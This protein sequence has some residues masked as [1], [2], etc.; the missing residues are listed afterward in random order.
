MATITYQA[1]QVDISEP[2]TLLEGLENA[3]FS[4][5]FSCRSGICHSC[6]MQA[7]EQ[8]PISSQVGLSDN[9]KAQHFFLA[10]SCIPNKAM[11]VNL[12]AATNKLSATVKDKQLVNEQVA[13]LKI[14][15]D[16]KW[17]PGQA[18]DI[19]F[20][21]LQARSYSIASRCEQEKI[22]EIHVKRH[23]QGLVSQWLYDRV[24]VGQ[25]LQL[26]KPF[27]DCFYNIDQQNK[28]LLLI[29]TGT[30]LA[31][32]YGIVQEAIH[33]QHKA[34]IYIYIAASKKADLYYVAEINSLKSSND[35]IH[36]RAAIRHSNGLTGEEVSD[37]EPRPSDIIENNIISLDINGYGGDILNLVKEKHTDLKGW[38][39]F[40]C[41]NPNM[42]KKAQ[43]ECF[44]LGA[45][46]GDIFADAFT[47]KKY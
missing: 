33:Q 3:G 11:K 41:G 34:P 15:V 24:S 32:L 47:V 25:S 7:D 28:P 23:E 8:P 31:P 36:Y 45:G 44:F 17:Y 9:Q 10:C 6:I 20:D 29:G 26:S 38:Q 43:R 27:G 30:G 35:N 1:Q 16:C 39:V 42:V 13:V 40:L 46:V 5:P 12:I 22:I 2:E 4:I 19:W 37:N 21:D 14:Q 18:I